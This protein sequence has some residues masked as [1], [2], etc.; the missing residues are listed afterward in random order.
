MTNYNLLIL[1]LFLSLFC[2][3]QDTIYY[4]FNNLETNRNAKYFGLKEY[5]TTDSNQ[6]ILTKY[7]FNKTPLSRTFY[8]NYLDKVKHNQQML[9][10]SSGMLA[11]TISYNFDTLHG[12]YITYDSIGKVAQ[13]E[14]YYKG[15]LTFIDTS[16]FH[17]NQQ[18]IK[19]REMKY[20]DPPIFQGCEKYYDKETRIR[21]T[22]NSMRYF[23]NQYKLPQKAEDENI[24]GSIRLSF[25]I[26]KNGE[27]INPTI[28][29]RSIDSYIFDS[30]AIDMAYKLPKFIPASEF[31]EAK[32]YKMNFII[33]FN[34]DMEHSELSN[35]TYY[36]TNYGF[37]TIRDRGIITQKADRMPIWKGCQLKGFQVTQDDCTEYQLER[38]IRKNV[39]YP[40]KFKKE[41]LRESVL[42]R[43]TVDESGKTKNVKL[44]FDSEF[45]EFNDAALMVFE[46]F[47]TFTPARKDGKP[48]PFDMSAAVN[49]KW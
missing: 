26:N 15:N 49:F 41:K 14:V 5:P 30:T 3:S 12:P 7:R 9:F 13:K 33:H 17:K 35:N 38:F 29:G 44:V 25:Y 40:E 43:F 31:G 45:K 27:I 42:V 19:K 2:K 16:L 47:P 24:T 48:I 39:V 11:K 1:L 22:Y 8:S 6:V 32:Y 20:T 28:S 37:R 21:C 4:S 36:Q 10:D 23:F 18:L 34:P 46:L